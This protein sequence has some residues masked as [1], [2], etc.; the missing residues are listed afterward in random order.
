MRFKNKKTEFKKKKTVRKRNEKSKKKLTD[1]EKELQGFL[2]CWFYSKEAIE[3]YPILLKHVEEN[4]KNVL[5]AEYNKLLEKNK[6][7]GNLFNLH[8]AKKNEKIENSR[9]CW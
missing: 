5:N 7:K 1:V 4:E 6:Q 3:Y 9:A 2:N 8:Q